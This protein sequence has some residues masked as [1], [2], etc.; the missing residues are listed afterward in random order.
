MDQIIQNTKD[1]SIYNRIGAGYA[2]T[3]REDPTIY[4]RIVT[5]LGGSKTVVN[6]GAGTGSY[7]PRNLNVI[8]VEP[9]EIMVQQR[10][11]S[12]APLI[13]ATADHLPIHDKSVDAAMTVLSI[14]HWHPHLQEGL[15]EMCRV[16]KKRV[17]IV[18]YDT[19]VSNRMWL[20]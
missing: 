19:R 16:A 11:L 13:K 15:K 7:E 3:R 6:V 20:F 4:N 5:A 2:Q 14:H 1:G 17:V 12:A 10:Q 8:A 9:S 18:T